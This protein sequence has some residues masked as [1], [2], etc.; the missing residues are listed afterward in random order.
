MMPKALEDNSSYTFNQLAYLGLIL[1]VQVMG[2][3]L[4]EMNRGYC[5]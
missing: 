1:K 4:Y 2:N 3:V 5:E